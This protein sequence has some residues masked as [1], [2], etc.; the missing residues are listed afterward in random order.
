MGYLRDPAKNILT[1]RANHRHYYILTQFVERR[2][3]C[4]DNGLASARLQYWGANAEDFA[5]NRYAAGNR[6]ADREVTRVRDCEIRFLSTAF[7]MSALPLTIPAMLR[8]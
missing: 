2:W 4:P 7:P 5:L 1:R 8:H 6:P 3:S